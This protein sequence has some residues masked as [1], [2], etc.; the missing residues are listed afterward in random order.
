M[1]FLDLRSHVWGMRELMFSSLVSLTLYLTA[2][3]AEQDLHKVMKH[4]ST[5]VETRI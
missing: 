4:E 2:C 5:T 3:D 1:E